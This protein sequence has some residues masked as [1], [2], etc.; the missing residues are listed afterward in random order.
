MIKLDVISDPV[1]PWCY[2]GKTNLARALEANPDHPFV[3]EW[4]PFQLNPDLPRE[5]L[6][7][8]SYLERK[9]GGPE[10]AATIYSRI[11][12]AAATAGLTI[13]WDAIETMPNTLDAHRVIHW[14]GIEGQQTPM[15]Q[16][17]FAAYWQEGRDIGDSDTLAELA[18]EVGMDSAAIRELLAGEA[19]LEDIKARDEHARTHGVTGVPTFIIAQQHVVSGAQPPDLWGKVIEDINAQLKAQAEGMTPEEAAAAQHG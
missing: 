12:E 6:D 18:G 4:H 10:E 9:F 7:R 19:D 11:E 2:I 13:D 17:L 15:V 14:A 3:I 8:K 5:G 1:C 16:R